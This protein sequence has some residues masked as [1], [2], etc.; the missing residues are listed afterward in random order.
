M[1]LSTRENERKECNFFVMEYDEC[2]VGAGTFWMTLYAFNVLNALFISSADHWEC[3][4]YIASL[5][6]S[7]G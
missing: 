5:L 4:G 6:L 7:T 1:S 2:V 3:P